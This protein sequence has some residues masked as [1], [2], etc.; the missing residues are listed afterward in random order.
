MAYV[1]RWSPA[2]RAETGG[3][4]LYRSTGLPGRARHVLALLRQPRNGV[5][6]PGD[7]RRG[8]NEAGPVLEMHIAYGGLEEPVSLETFTV[9]PLTRYIRLSLDGPSRE[10][11]G[12]STSFGR[13]IGRESGCMTR[14]RHRAKS[15]KR[16]GGAGIKR[17]ETRGE[18]GRIY[19]FRETDGTPKRVY[20]Q[21][22]AIGDG[23]GALRGLFGPVPGYTHH[24][25]FKE[26]GS[27]RILA[28]QW[29]S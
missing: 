25:R 15:K 16:N 17:Y 11:G 19:L 2:V 3:G 24:P 12:R 18:S 14:S 13:T 20:G 6:F 22:L 7:A 10:R 9:R 1:R 8:R 21:R 29:G 4:G 23:A 26:I 27:Y 5:R 28:C